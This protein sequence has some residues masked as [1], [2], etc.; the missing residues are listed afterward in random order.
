MK[1][2]LSASTLL[3]GFLLFAQNIYPGQELIKN[4]SYH[5]PTKN[6]YLV[7]QDDGNLVL[8]PKRSNTA[9]WDS[10]T[11]NIGQKAMFQQDGNLVVYNGNNSAV[12]STKTQNR[13]TILKVQ[14]D[15]NLVVYNNNNATWSS[16]DNSPQQG[17]NSYTPDYII[18]KGYEFRM[19]SKIYSQNR[20]YYLTFQNDGNLVVYDRNGNVL[21]DSKTSNRGVKAVFQSDGN[22][23]VTDRRGEAI[24]GSKT[25]NRNVS[26]L[27]LQNDGNLVISGMSDNPIWASDDD[28]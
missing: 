4:S 1:K 15:G 16:M 5:S 6:Y 13:G 17:G 19:N 24:Y 12:F 14:D 3:L 20:N 8:Y 9:V 7:F 22:L 11:S 10:K 27:K 2:I 25:N 21:W 28:R 23:V 26:T 18:R